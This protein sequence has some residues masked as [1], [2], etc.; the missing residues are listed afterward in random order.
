MNPANALEQFV[1]IPGKRQD[2]VVLVAHADTVWDKDWMNWNRIHKPERGTIME[3]AIVQNG[4]IISSET[5]GF[6]IGADDRAGCAILWLLKDSGHSLLITNGEEHRQVGSNWLMNNHLDIAQELNTHLFM[7]QLDRENAKE[8]KCYTVGTDEFRNF[9]S[10]TT[11]YTEPDRLRT[12]DI[13]VLCKDICGVNFSIG[14]YD[15]HTK[16]EII[17]IDE[18][19]NTL[20][21]V[22]HLIDSELN[23]FI[24]D[25]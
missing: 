15:D 5:S 4:N 9:I 7:I 8:F 23:G 2:K 1:Y 11:A 20:E 17:K 21:M 18:W 22:R 3:H 14:Y 19:C 13:G 25:N 10:T 6:G 24:L 16:N 12:T